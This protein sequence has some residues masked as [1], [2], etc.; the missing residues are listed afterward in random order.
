MNP[1]IVSVTWLN[2]HI[3][4]ENLI[5]LD[6]TL[7]NQLLKLSSD[8][9]GVQI[10][11]ARFFDI[12]N[13]FS[14]TANDFPSAYPTQM[15]FEEEA[16]TLGINNNSVIVVYDS[17]GIYSSPRAWWLFKSMGHKEVYVLNG[18]LP[19]WLKSN[20]PV[21]KKSKR[22]YPKGSFKAKLNP[23][24][25]RRF[26]DVLENLSSKKELVIDVR[27]EDR[28]NGVVPEPREG[29]RS[30]KIENSIN[31]PYTKVIENGKFKDEESIKLLFKFLENESRNIVFSCGSGIT[32]CVVF[33][34]TEGILANKKS[35]YD[36]SWTEWGE[37]TDK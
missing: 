13:K 29:L 3:N 18:G 20:F 9:Q 12:K 32:A 11:N 25:V 22:T 15:Q 10:K 33:L 6:C 23:D 28:F 17:N 35:V 30:G 5:V 8:I 7:N 2:N 1:S 24:F 21:E 4:D 31:L 37:K 34:A 26:D 14:D 27:S 19:E 16:Q 36:G